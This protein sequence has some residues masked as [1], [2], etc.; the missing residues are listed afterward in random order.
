MI[1]EFGELIDEAPY[2]LEH[3]VDGFAEEAAVVVRLEVRCLFFCPLDF[4]LLVA[5]TRVL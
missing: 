1:G 2:L 4:C 5:N 3:L